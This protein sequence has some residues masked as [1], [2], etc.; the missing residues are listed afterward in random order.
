MLIPYSVYREGFW[1]HETHQPSAKP[2]N[3]HVIKIT[4]EHHSGHEVPKARVSWSRIPR[5]MELDLP[6]PT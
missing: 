1:E 5:F 2:I 3:A 4:W 6:G